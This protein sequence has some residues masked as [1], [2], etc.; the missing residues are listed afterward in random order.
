MRLLL[1]PKL[2]PGIRIENLLQGHGGNNGRVRIGRHGFGQNLDCHIEVQTH[3][4]P[5]TAQIA[6][7]HS[8][9]PAQSQQVEH[10]CWF[11]NVTVGAT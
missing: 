9:D 2:D 10:R 8:P 4:A 7:P 11:E 1:A 6:L 3:V 5:T